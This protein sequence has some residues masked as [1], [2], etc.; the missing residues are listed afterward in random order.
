MGVESD[1]FV[2][3][4]KVQELLLLRKMMQTVLSEAC[5]SGVPFPSHNHF[6]GWDT[7][8]HPLSFWFVPF[9]S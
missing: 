4:K 7:K 8:E 6:C 1:V 9:P 2:E 5:V 3:V